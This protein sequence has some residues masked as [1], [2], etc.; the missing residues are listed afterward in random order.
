M[1][2]AD[3][4]SSDDVYGVHKFACD[5]TC[6]RS[7]TSFVKAIFP[8][9]EAYTGSNLSLC[10]FSTQL[11]DPARMT[12]NKLF[13]I[14]RMYGNYLVQERGQAMQGRLLALHLGTLDVA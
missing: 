7:T 2:H 14:F 4:H 5:V 8:S 9:F 12:T 1:H 10:T 3:M 11:P 13:E 6:L